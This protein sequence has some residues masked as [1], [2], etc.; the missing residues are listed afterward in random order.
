MVLP[1]VQR[2]RSSRACRAF[3]SLFSVLRF[4]FSVLRGGADGAAPAFL[5][6][7]GEG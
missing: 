2:S 4:L 6:T 3:R 7:Q 1:L 5:W